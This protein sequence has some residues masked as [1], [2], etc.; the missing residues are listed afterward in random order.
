MKPVFFSLALF[1]LLSFPTKLSSQENP[2]HLKGKVKISISE[3]TFECDLTMSNIPY[4]QDYFVRLNN[5]MN[6]LHFWSKKPNDFILGYDWS[7][8]TDST[9][10]GETLAYFFPDNTRKGKF[11]PEEIQ[12]RYVGKFPVATDTIENYSR[13]DWK[14][15][16]AFNGYSVR[17]DGTQSAWYP[18]I[19]D[20]KNDIRY[21]QMTY[22]IEL[23]CE[24][25][26]TIYVNGHQPIK[27]SFAKII[28]Q[29]P[30]ELALFCGKFG[31]VDDGNIIILNSQYS[32][33]EVQQLSDIVSLY[34]KYYEQKLDIKF[35][36]KLVFVNSTPTA[37]NY[38]WL[39]VSYPTIMGIG[40]A[41]N[42]LGA[43][44][45]PKVQEWYKHHIAHELSH[46]YFGT[47]KVFNS[48]LGDMMSEGF[49][50]YTSLK[51]IEDLSGIELY[52][53]KLERKFEYLKNYVTKPFSQIKLRADIENRQ[54]FVY[55]YAPIIFLAIEQEIGK[56]KMW[57]W[58]KA[59]L[60]T[61]TEFTDYEFLTSTLR[62]TLKDNIK[63]GYLEKTY[64]TSEN[65]L[66][67]ALNKL[68][69]K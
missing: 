9:S 44:F 58:I 16:I 1:L 31:F 69:N 59:I 52:N 66:V 20:T 34:K 65:S 4:I 26:E 28:S 48:T 29:D 3:G 27:S 6:V 47:F 7:N 62:N 25:C 54:H 39:F 10:T 5:G 13:Y 37:P 42:G 68:N 63:F 35:E 2:P 32:K 19:Y 15:N 8:C 36:Q 53:E 49:S 41:K 61:K 40:Y 33:D 18:Y 30:Y 57:E 67:N 21:D 43:L 22:D 56:E 12:F 17:T 38:G 11:L 45:D 46:Y 51:L 64:F 24:D 60:E 50:E 14:G 23:I 55:D